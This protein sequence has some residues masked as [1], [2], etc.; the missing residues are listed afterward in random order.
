MYH[1]CRKGNLRYLQISRRDTARKRKWRKSSKKLRGSMLRSSA[2]AGKG[3]R[4]FGGKT[5][6][7]DQN[8]ADA[9]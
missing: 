5:S 3:G 7:S 2:A 8:G 9:A 1:S 6:E 4:I